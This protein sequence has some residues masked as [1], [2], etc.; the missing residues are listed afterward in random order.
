MDEDSADVFATLKARRQEEEYCL[1]FLDRNRSA[2]HLK[3]GEEADLFF[4]LYLGNYLYKRMSRPAESEKALKSKLKKSYSHKEQFRENRAAR[5]VEYVL[6][7]KRDFGV[8]QVRVQELT[9]K[10]SDE[11]EAQIAEHLRRCAKWRAHIS[12]TTTDL[13]S[14]MSAV[15]SERLCEAAVQLSVISDALSFIPPF[16]KSM[17]KH[18]HATDQVFTANSNLIP[19]FC[20]RDYSQP[21]R[22]DTL[23]L[24]TTLSEG[25]REGSMIPAVAWRKARSVCVLQKPL[26]LDEASCQCLAESLGWKAVFGADVDYSVESLYTLL[27]SATEDLIVFGFPCDSSQFTLL[28]KQFN[29]A[30]PSDSFV[31]RPTPSVVEPFDLIVELDIPDETV[32]RDVLAVLED[33]G[34]DARYD[35]RELFLD[36]EA[37]LVR[38]RPAADP[39]LDVEQYAHR[40]ATLESH[41]RLIE[42]GSHSYARVAMESR[43][44]SDE[45]VERVQDRVGQIAEP[46]EPAYPPQTVHESLLQAVRPLSGELK[47][48]FAEQW[49]G[50]EAHYRTAVSHAFE[51]LHEAHLLVIAHLDQSRREMQA[52]LARPGSS[53][54]H[55]IEFQQWHCTQIER[56]MRRIQRVKDECYIRLAALREQLLQIETDRKAEEEA[57]QRDLTNAPFRAI[58][59]ELVNNAATL[60]AQAELDRWTAT[61]TL[62]VD[63][64]QIVSDVDLVPPI[65]HKKFTLLVDSTRSQKGRQQKKQPRGTPQGRARV[66]NKLL[67]FESPLFE[68]LEAMKRYVTDAAVVYVRVTT[69]VSNRAKSRPTKDKNPFAPNKFTALDEF[70]TGFADDDV[71]VTG[72]FDEITELARSEIYL[73]QQSFDAFVDDSNRWIQEHYERKKAIV[74]TAIAYLTGRVNDEAQVNHLVLLREDKC[75]IDHQQLLVANEEVPKVPIPFSPA[76]IQELPAKSPEGFIQGVVAFQTETNGP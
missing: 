58:L 7:R 11:Y 50:V 16:Y 21:L 56:C 5:N 17:A 35:V 28:H 33:T 9:K 46:A 69:P 44:V 42:E 37:Q 57:R 63:F 31:P 19:A 73:I 49:D 30:A 2:L 72:K 18:F 70:L 65:P 20:V 66:E 23:R 14:N 64:N 76:Q 55:V 25:C 6:Q 59:F 68:Q 71:F 47:E 34:S 13:V 53:Q 22:A 61:R 75:V 48:F 10:L 60:L 45:F 3:C 51:L 36:T 38:L 54:H 15:A 40:A 74:D 67:P 62:L 32:L 27:C 41:F 4:N 26:V 8:S 24:L 29:R 39:Q 1:A 12:Q 52:F 43:L